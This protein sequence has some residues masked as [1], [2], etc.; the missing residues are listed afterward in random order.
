MEVKVEEV[1]VEQTKEE[2]TEQKPEGDVKTEG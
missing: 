1:K 2:S